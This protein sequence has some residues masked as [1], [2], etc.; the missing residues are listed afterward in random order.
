MK[1]DGAVTIVHQT[2]DYNNVVLH[3]NESNENFFRVLWKESN[4]WPKASNNRCGVCAVV[5]G[6]QCL[7]NT[8][9][10]EHQ[11]FKEAP[12][13]IGEALSSLSI[14]A[15]NPNIYAASSFTSETDPNTG[16]TTY[17][18]SGIVN[19]DTVFELIDD[20]G[21]HY[22]LKNIRENVYVY[23]SEGQYSGFSFQNAPHF[24]SLVPSE[25]TVRYVCMYC[26]AKSIY[27]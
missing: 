16:I 27:S 3:V 1:K 11:V 19:K 5:S 4:A 26:T 14:G 10:R 22:F 25:T 13:S 8:G 6:D 24:M 12:R 18:K 2:A 20:K 7:C 15:P 9:V 17:L 21:R 23:G